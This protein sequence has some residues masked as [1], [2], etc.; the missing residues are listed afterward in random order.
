MLNPLR[1]EAEAFR[2]LL[3]VIAVFAVIIGAI[4]IIRAISFLISIT[5]KRARTWACPRVGTCADL[6]QRRT[7]AAGYS[8]LTVS[9][10]TMPLRAR[11]PG[12]W[13]KNV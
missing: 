5:W 7:R 1:S 12:A 3:Y 10:P 9:V 13:Q 11:W 6:G 8:Y 4:L 2:L